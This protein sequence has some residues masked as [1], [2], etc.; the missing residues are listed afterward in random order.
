MSTLYVDTITEKTAGNGVQI[1]GHVVQVVQGVKSDTSVLTSTSFADIG[2]SANITPSSTTSKILVSVQLWGY[3]GHYVAPN[4][5]MR[6]TT[7]IGAASSAG[8]RPS[9]ALP[10]S[11]PPN[12]DGSMSV[13]TVQLLDSPSTTSQITYKVQSAIRA[14]G[15]QS[16]YINRSES[17][18]DTASYDPRTVSYIT[19]MEI[20][21]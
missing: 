4:R 1:P 3:S 10:F 9:T 12:T 5:L 18:R 20:A 19:L 15:T 21:Q 8:N 14:D 13:A 16:S 11:L 17:D 7:E 6:D 2:L